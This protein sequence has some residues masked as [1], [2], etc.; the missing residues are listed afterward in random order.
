MKNASGLYKDTIKIER[1]KWKV[2]WFIILAGKSPYQMCWIRW[3][4]GL[5]QNSTIIK[6][7]SEWWLIS[8]LF[9]NALEGRCGADVVLSDF[10]NCLGCQDSLVFLWLTLNMNLG[11]GNNVD[12][13]ALLYYN[14][15]QWFIEKFV[16]L[17]ITK[18]VFARC[19]FAISSW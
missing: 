14:W 1:P 12:E 11:H 9:C 15:D 17:F 4:S 5:T 13:C 18:I 3:T 7:S 8:S 10:W 16:V 2:F 6:N 19:T